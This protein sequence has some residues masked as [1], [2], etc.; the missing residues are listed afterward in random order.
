MK[1]VFS[2]IFMI[3]ALATSLVSCVKEDQAFNPEASPSVVGF[4]NVN[5][6]ISSPT[7]TPIP[8]FQAAFDIMPAAEFML[9]ISYSGPTAAPN[10]V[11][12]TVEVDPTVV[13]TYN[14]EVN[15][16]DPY[17]IMPTTLYTIENPTAIIKKGERIGYIKVIVKTADFDLDEMYAVGLKIKSTTSGGISLNYGTAVYRLDAKNHWDGEYKVTG[18]YVDNDNPAFKGLYPYNHMFL[19]T[20]SANECYAYN[21]DYGLTGFV[22][23][24]GTGASYYSNWTPQFRF[25]AGKVVEVTNAYGQGAGTRFGKLS[26]DGANTVTESGDVITIDVKYVMVQV[27]RDRCVFTEKWVKTGARP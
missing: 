13:T 3:G 27:T 19:I 10:D 9:P 25:D 16:G 15:E 2:N 8:M 1:K 17:T 11:S 12:V 21:D 7:S 5:N 20:A 14:D 4:R 6:T 23:N 26:P 24:T 22:F 18:S